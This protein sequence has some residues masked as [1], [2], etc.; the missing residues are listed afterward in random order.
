MKKTIFMM[1]ILAASVM[2]A[3]VECNGNK[4]AIWTSDAGCVMQ[5]KNHYAAGE[6]VWIAGENFCQQE[7]DWSI[8]GLPGKASCNPGQAVAYDDYTVGADGTFCIK[9][10]TVQDTDCGEYKV[11]FGGKKDNYRVD[12]VVPEFST[13]AGTLAFA[14][15]AIGYSLLRK[16]R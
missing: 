7:Y 2:A 11:E 15:A 8:V 10:Y 1:L 6:E 9:A 16:R 3:K 12:E 5:N 14:G 4:G 13:I